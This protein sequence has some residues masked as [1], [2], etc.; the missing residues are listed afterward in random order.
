MTKIPYTYEIISVTERNM[1]VRYENPDHGVMHV[2]VRL[3]Y[4]GEDLATVIDQFSPALFWAEQLRPVQAVPVGMTGAGETTV[5]IDESDF[6][7]DELLAMWRERAVIS[8]LQAHYTL[9]VWG[10]Y[11][12]VVALVEAL[13]DPLE[14]AFQRA[15]EWRRNSPTILELFGNLQMPDGTAPTPADVDRFFQE[16]AGFTL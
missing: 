13:G 2:G 3:P 6:T 12:Q 11:D 9:K 16:A 15:T 10:L 14:L 4:E 1:E 7:P 8:Q 5:S